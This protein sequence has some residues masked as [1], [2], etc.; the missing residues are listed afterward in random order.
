MEDRRRKSPI[1]WPYQP[2]HSPSTGYSSALL[3]LHS[4]VLCR[5]YK[6]ETSNLK[7]TKM[8]TKWSTKNVHSLYL[9]VLYFCI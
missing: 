5:F 6:H 9:I 1:N 8:K 3:E 7:D 2:K 4:V